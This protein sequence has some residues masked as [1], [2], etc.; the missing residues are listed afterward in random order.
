[1]THWM[2]KLSPVLLKPEFSENPDKA[3]R[4]IVEMAGRHT[5]KISSYAKANKGQVHRELGIIPSLVIEVPYAAIP[6]LALSRHVKKIWHDTK[7][8]AM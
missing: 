8:R 5:D 6:D 1:M 7:V 3:C 4:V 2:Q